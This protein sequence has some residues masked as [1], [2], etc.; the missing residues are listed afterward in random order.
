VGPDYSWDPCGQHGY[1][2][3][4]FMRL[5]ERNNFHSQH[6]PVFPSFGLGIKDINWYHNWMDTYTPPYG[7]QITQFSGRVRDF[8]YSMNQASIKAKRTGETTI[9]L[10]FGESQPFFSRYMV[11]VKGGTATESGSTYLWTIGSGEN[12]ITVTPENKWGTQGL[13]STLKIIY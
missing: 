9:E 2:T 7:T 5:T 6:D 8:W 12:T 3:C 4:G 1:T 13:A 11:S 10:E